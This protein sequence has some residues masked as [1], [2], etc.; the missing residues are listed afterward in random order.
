MKR[1]RILSFDLD[2]RALIL[3]QYINENWDD[4]VKRAQQASQMR[5]MAGLLEQYGTHAI[6]AKLQNFIEIGPKPIS[7]L[8]FHNRFF[9]QVRDAFVVG[10]HY[11]ALTAAC[12]LG[13]RIL[14]HLILLLRQDFARTSETKEVYDKESIRNWDLAIKTLETWNVL[15]PRTVASF[16]K[17]KEIRSQAIHFRPETD[18]ND[19]PLALEA[20]RLLNAIIDEQFTSFGSRPWFITN[21]PGECY[22]KKEA[23][24]HPFI[25]RIYIPNSVYV[26][27]RHRVEFRGGQFI[28]S[29][30]DDYEEREISDEEFAE[31]RKL[32]E[33]A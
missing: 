33:H 3:T 7:I 20:I 24:E 13:E 18:Q 30:D 10:A 8:A 22:L 29:D 2:R 31:L 6:E 12:A 19:R 21:I 27:P 32:S 1:Y 28:V 5:I 9:D 15:L 23:E 25:R 26:G 17:L 4:A 14:N 11:P 16:W